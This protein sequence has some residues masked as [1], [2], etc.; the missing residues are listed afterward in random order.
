[1]DLIWKKRMLKSL[2]TREKK[3]KMRTLKNLYS[4]YLK[5]KNVFPRLGRIPSVDMSGRF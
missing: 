3:E 4:W 1:M 2:L 5:K